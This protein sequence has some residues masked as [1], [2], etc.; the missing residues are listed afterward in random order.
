VDH[1]S[2]CP[3]FCRIAFQSICV[4]G[5]F[6]QKQKHHRFREHHGNPIES[7]RRTLRAGDRRNRLLCA[8]F[9][10]KNEEFASKGRF[11]ALEGLRGFAA[12]FVFIHHS[13]IWWSYALGHPWTVPPPKLYRNL[14]SEP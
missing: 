7:L 1:R 14:A 13:A 12:L 8:H 10:A 5:F 11:P 2:G 4:T 9:L 6:P 3:G